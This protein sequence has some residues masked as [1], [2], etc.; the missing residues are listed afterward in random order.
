MHPIG[1]LRDQT[2]SEAPRTRVRG[3]RGRW[4]IPVT[5]GALVWGG[6]MLVNFAWPRLA[7]N[8]TPGLG[9]N[10]HWGWLNHRPALWT[11]LVVILL[12]GAAYYL[13]VQRTKPAHA[14]A[15][16]DELVGAEV[17]ASAASPL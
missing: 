9:L 3:A 13:L 2:P 12:V 4:G 1:E 16:D 15:P 10:F 14:Q 6:A 17:A 5:V 7:T 8:P 11:V